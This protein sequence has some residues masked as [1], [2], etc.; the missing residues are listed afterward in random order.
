MTIYT[1]SDFATITLT[2]SVTDVPPA[3]L[4]PTWTMLIAGF[5]GLGF[6]AYHRSKK[7]AASLAAA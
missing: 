2:S 5:I 4:P 3:P 1:T 7:S 6:V